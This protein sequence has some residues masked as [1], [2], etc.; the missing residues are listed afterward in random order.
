MAKPIGLTKFMREHFYLIARLRNEGL[1]F[2]QIAD[3]LPDMPRPCAKG[4]NLRHCYRYAFKMAKK[5]FKNIHIIN[6]RNQGF[7]SFVRDNFNKISSMRAAGFSWR[8]IASKLNLRHRF[9]LSRNFSAS[10]RTAFNF[11]SRERREHV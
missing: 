10:L 2:R 6:I 4:K 9:P 5:S 1:T 11:F 7:A 3:A 8:E